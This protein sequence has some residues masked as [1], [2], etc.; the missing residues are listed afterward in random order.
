MS[1]VAAGVRQ[2]GDWVGL[3]DGV[4]RRDDAAVARFIDRYRP[5]LHRVVRV[6]GTLR[7]L[8]GLLESQDIVQS[9]FVQVID[10]IAGGRVFANEAALEGY[11]AAV[12][13]NNLRDAIRR[14]RAR[15]RGGDGVRS[16][17]SGLVEQPGSDPTPSQV[18]AVR[19]EIA[20]V[21]AVAPASELEV[22]REK[23]DGADWKELAEARGLDPDALRKRIERVRQRIREALDGS[24]S[25]GQ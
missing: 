4:R 21:E 1:D 3:F 13:R 12:G 16:E 7:R 14:E 15:K 19:E 17:G 24:E 5:L 25:S 2:D 11:L 8:Q 23:V 20:R 6:R 9:V 22:L 10:E 18:V